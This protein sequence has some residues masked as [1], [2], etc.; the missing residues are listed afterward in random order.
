VLQ[1]HNVYTQPGGEDAIADAE[2]ALLRAA[3]HE[4][5]AMR[6]QNP[7]GAVHAARAL[8]AAPWNPTRYRAMRRTVR[9]CRPDVAHVHNTW[10]ALTPAVLTAL[11]AERV[12]V[13]MTLQNYRLLCVNAFLFRD[14]RVCTDCVGTHPWHG[15][16]HACYRDSRPQSAIAAAT[17]TTNRALR[18]WDHV[19]RFVAPSRFVRQVFIDAGVAADRITVKPNTVSDPGPRPAPPS[20]ANEVVY[21]GRLSPEKGVDTLLAGWAKAGGTVA[22]M[23]LVVVGEGPQRGELERMA[24]AGVRFT[25]WLAA[26]DLQA[27]LLRARALVFPSVWWENF[28]R[29]IIE[30]MAAG[31]PVMASDIAT[32]AEV[33]AP[34]GAGW[35]VPPGDAPAWAAHLA[36]LGDDSFV[37]A[38]GAAARAAFESEFAPD[39]G[40]DRLLAVYASVVGAAQNS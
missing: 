2:A 36:R 39:V 34:L 24:V 26:D 4:V 38:G 27:L 32:P 7:E 33:V 9:E 30:A 37:D 10:F 28:G 1:V 17:I 22:G 20:T 16:Q 5:T 40:L 23:E 35:L 21:A 18:T 6:V 12:P 29:V 14:G 19:D 11:R 13:V 3:G 15:V 31:L 25:G 8:A